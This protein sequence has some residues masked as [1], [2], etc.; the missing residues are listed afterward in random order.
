MI[1]INEDEKIYL[2]IRRHWLVLFGKIASL[3]LAFLIPLILYLG[4]RLLSSFVNME[5]D[6]FAYIPTSLVL[7]VSATWSLIIWTQIFI[8]WTNYYLDTWIITDKRIIDIEQKGLFKRETAFFRIDKLQDVKADVH[9]I[10][11][12]WLNFGN[13]H[14]KTAGST[15]TF[16]IRNAP[17]PQEIKRVILNM[18]DTAMEAR[19]TVRIEERPE[20]INESS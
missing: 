15:S 19:K 4:I 20:A 9:G 14:V 18:V 17:N 12:T 10:L 16:T 6:F 2:V 7:F 3:A 5:N 1:H 8:I 13:V 11:A